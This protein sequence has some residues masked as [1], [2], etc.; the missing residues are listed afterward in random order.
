MHSVTSLALVLALALTHQAPTAK[1]DHEAQAAI[2]LAK[3][4]AVNAKRIAANVSA[5]TP[6]KCDGTCC[7]SPEDAR[8]AAVERGLPIVV[9]VVVQPKPADIVALAGKAVICKVR[10]Y[11]A[12]LDPKDSAVYKATPRVWLLA[13]KPDKSAFVLTKR[14]APDEFTG[15]KAVAEL[16]PPPPR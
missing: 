5:A 2:A 3:A 9:F 11:E 15:V 4:K 12:D 7:D 16:A 6:A 13:L 8:K 1:G 10:E 14:W